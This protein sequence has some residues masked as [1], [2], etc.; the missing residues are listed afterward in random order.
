MLILLTRRRHE[1]P[2]VVSMSKFATLTPKH[3]LPSEAGCSQPIVDA[4]VNSFVHILSLRGVE[5][6]VAQHA[7][8]LE[9][10]PKLSCLDSG[11]HLSG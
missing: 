8:S 5:N 7:L 1:T 9:L 4:G 10:S 3:G 2:V 11:T 6:W